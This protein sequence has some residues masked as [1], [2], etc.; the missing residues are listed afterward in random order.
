MQ[1]KSNWLEWFF[2]FL[3]FMKLFLFV[4]HRELEI[5]LKKVVDC[6]GKKKV[7]CEGSIQYL[8][9]GYEMNRVIKS[10][11]LFQISIFLVLVSVTYQFLH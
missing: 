3:F 6:P 10:P 5:V 1:S 11:L 2:Y 4:V 8:N 9:D 7:D